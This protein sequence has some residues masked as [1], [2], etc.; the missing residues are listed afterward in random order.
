METLTIKLLHERKSRNPRRKVNG[1][2]GALFT[3][4]WSDEHSAYCYT[5]A[6]QDEA[7]DL[8]NSQGRR[9]GAY[10]APVITI[11]PVEPPKP[12]T[13]EVASALL[14]RSLPENVAGDPES[15][16][17]ALLAAYDRGHAMGVKFA[18]DRIEHAAGVPSAEC[19]VPNETVTKVDGPTAVAQFEMTT[20][21]E[22]NGNRESAS[23]NP[24]PKA[25]AA[26]AK[27]SDTLAKMAQA[28]G[29]G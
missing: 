3:F 20:T 18:A 9:F 12:L 22:P 16:A 21:A 28:V 5:T 1:A 15:I 10:F 26:K 11:K 24:K 7:D 6:S 17:L 25:K 27:S 2:S 13:L 23:A 4:H 19:Q 14:E 8:F 29:Q